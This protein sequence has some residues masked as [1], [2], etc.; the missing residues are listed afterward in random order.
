[1]ADVLLE[2]VGPNGNIQAVVEADDRVCYFYLFSAPETNLGM[3]AVWVR[4]LAR[5]SDSLD[6]EGMRAGHPPQN[7]AAYCRHPGGMPRPDEERLSVTWLPEGNGA[8]LYEGDELLAIIP[9]WSGAKG[10]SGYARDSI[11]DG[12][13]AWEIG[14][15]NVLIERFQQAQTYWSKWD[16]EDLWPSIQAAIMEPIEAAIGRHS[17]YYAIDGGEWPPKALIRLP[18]KESIV[19]VTIGVSARPQPNVEMSTD[20]PEMWRRIE[21]GVVLPEH[22]PNEAINR[23]ASYLS[24][25]SNLPWN[26][27]TWLGPG[28]TLPCDSW[29][30]P[31]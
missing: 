27:C 1:M 18:H 20:H 31:E 13:V 14:P 5:A 12:P 10:F 22:W 28:H 9:P 7:P 26:N 30:N 2:E 6:V 29:L 25:Q 23:F 4:N 8:A 17:N 11:G 3:K 21:F 19:L 15:D 24:G 16:E